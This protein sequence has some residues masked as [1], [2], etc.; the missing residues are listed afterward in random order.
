MMRMLKGLASALLGC[1]ALAGTIAATAGAD[2]VVF[3]AGDIAC[4]PTDSAFNGGA[5]TAAAC[6]QLDT[7]N[8]TAGATAVLALGDLQYNNG[9]LSN[10][11]R[12]YNA[13]WGRF[14]ASTIPVIGNHEGIT[15]TGGAGFCAYFGAA[16]HC[17]SGGRQGNAVFYSVDV[18]TW[19]VVVLNSNCTAAGGCGVRSAQYQWLASDLASHPRACTL[20]A[21][22]HPRWSTGHDGSNAFMQPIWK[23]LYDNGADLVLAGHSHDYERFAPID[24]SGVVNQAD[25]MRSFVVGTGG[26]HFTG[27]GASVAPGSELRNNNS[28][29]VLRLDLHATSYDWNF[30]PVSG[31]TLSDSGHQ[32]CRGGGAGWTGGGGGR[33]LGPFRASADAAVKQASP[34]ANFGTSTSLNADRGTGARAE[35]YARFNVSGVAGRPVTSAKLRLYVNGNGAT[36][37]PGIYGCIAAAAC[38]A[39]SESGI[40]WA[41]RPARAPTATATTGAITAPTWVEWEVT[42]L[43]SGDGTYTLVVGPTPTTDGV[44]FRSDEATTNKPEL[45][46]TV[47]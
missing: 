38:A 23:L 34:T 31:M 13:S 24:G 32:N 27:L 41:T 6:R 46:V 12:S 36:A 22:H 16:A 35:S 28:F 43:I 44:G 29:G 25:G 30:L 17:N 19:H 2:P 47:G 42:P 10:F 20:A 3:A 40:T 26:A 7:S 4:D 9:S 21:W 8:L 5:G 11:Q 1:V 14:K 18:G 37:G 33:T 39:W 15:A 45:V